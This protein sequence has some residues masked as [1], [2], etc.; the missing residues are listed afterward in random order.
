MP[1]ANK[2][3]NLDKLGEKLDST[4]QKATELTEKLEK[5]VPKAVDKATASLK[6]TATELREFND[7]LIDS[8]KDFLKLAASIGVLDEATKK[9]VKAMDA[10]L[11]LKGRWANGEVG[12]GLSEKELLQKFG[13]S[14]INKVVKA[15]KEH[16]KEQRKIKQEQENLANAQK[17]S[18]KNTK[19][20]TKDYQDLSKALREVLSSIESVKGALNSGSIRVRVDNSGFTKVMDEMK[21]AIDNFNRRKGNERKNF[22]D[23]FLGTREENMAKGDELVSEMK[24]VSSKLETALTTNLAGGLS[25]KLKEQI[26]NGILTGVTAGLNAVATIDKQAYASG[27]LKAV[28]ASQPTKRRVL[29]AILGVTDL[30]EVAVEKTKQEYITKRDNVKNRANA[31]A[32]VDIAAV[33]RRTELEFAEANPN[34]AIA[35]E[36]N[37]KARKAENEATREQIKLEQDL[38]K[39]KNDK[40]FRDR[41]QEEMIRAQKELNEVIGEEGSKLKELGTKLVELKTKQREYQIQSEYGNKINFSEQLNNLDQIAKKTKEWAA[42]SYKVEHHYYQIEKMGKAVVNTLK[43]TSSVFQ[44]TSASLS[45]FGGMFSNVDSFLHTLSG[46]FTNMFRQVFSYARNEVKSLYN[47]GLEQYEKI[48]QAQIGF[49]SFFGKDRVDQITS[50]VRAEAAKTPIVNAGD[51]ADYVMQLAPVSQG[52]ASLALNSSLGILKSLVYSGSDISEGEYVIKNIRDVIAKGTATAIDIR[53]FNRALPGLENAIKQMPELADFI[54]ENGKLSITKANVGKVLDVFAKLNTSEDSPLKDIEEEQLKTLAGMKELF[55]EKRTTAMESILRESGV[56][57]LLYDILGVATNDSM[58]NKVVNFVSNTLRPLVT[59]LSDILNNADW[60]GIANKLK[61]YWGIIKEGIDAAKETIM[62]TGRNIL[63]TTSIDDVFTKISRIVSRFIK[64]IGD[65]VKMA[66]EFLQWLANM[67][68]GGDLE[69]LA[70]TIGMVFFSPLKKIIQTV[71]GFGANT[72]GAASRVLSTMSKFIEAVNKTAL[73]A[74][75]SNAVNYGQMYAAATPQNTQ[76][77]VTTAMLGEL[78]GGAKTAASNGTK[79]TT[80]TIPND[81]GVKI[82]TYSTAQEMGKFK[83]FTS[84]ASAKLK[85]FGNNLK[86]VGAKLLKGVMVGGIVDTLG[87]A[88]GE[89]IKAMRLFGDASED[90]GNAVKSVAEAIAFIAVGASVGGI[91]GGIVGAGVFLVKKLIDMANEIETKRKQLHDEVESI[92]LEGAKAQYAETAMTILRENGVNTD[93]GTDAGKYAYERMKKWLDETDLSYLSPEQIANKAA[94]EF[95][96]ALR[97]KNIAE[98]IVSVSESDEYKNAGGN[99]INLKDSQWADKRNALAEKIEYYRLLGDS[100]NYDSMSAESIVKQF[101][102]GDSITDKQLDMYLSKFG[103]YEQTMSTNTTDITSSL[104]VMGEKTDAVKE[105]L[106]KLNTTI[107]EGRQKLEENEKE[108]GYYNAMFPETALGVSTQHKIEEWDRADDYLYTP[109]YEIDGMK[110]Y[111]TD[112]QEAFS[113]KINE[114]AAKLKELKENGLADSD[115]YKNLQEEL[116]GIFH[117]YHFWADGQYQEVGSV[118]EKMKEEYTWF[119]DKLKE[120]VEEDYETIHRQFLWWGWDEKVRKKNTGGIVFNHGGTVRPIYRATGGEAGVDTVPA[121]LQPGEFVMRKSSVAKVGLST[122]FALNRGDMTAAARSL[123]TRFSGN[124]NNSRNW[125]NTVN[126]NQKSVKNFIQV[127]NRNASSRLN[128]YYGM[129]NRIALAS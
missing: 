107:D 99:V 3:S 98:E 46:K 64:G 9:S 24:S 106:D 122:L 68:S 70:E 17:K 30:T 39:V 118:V 115:E 12:K 128:T 33:T 105:S 44:T 52:N 1:R 121:M 104:T 126:N 41:N 90:I 112:I 40:A 35:S 119:G 28:D 48:Q 10:L 54:D 51:L 82:T 111:H 73:S 125:S 79:V 5:G 16:I 18:N 58:W 27:L 6:S 116:D 91:T 95:A 62:N 63:G 61:T 4:V 96:H 2:S 100:A 75:N 87:S 38:A 42:E 102:G 101:L 77:L 29:D 31:R 84:D 14:A 89:G 109:D 97:F 65:G 72:F 114:M 36:L 74:I 66:M 113:S 19:E 57:D 43:F 123:G 37:A 127:N 23:Q 80:K 76:N 88:I 8:Q 78:N 86:I 22:F 81:N 20:T 45:S 13:Y 71:I 83:T 110:V 129:A 47:E 94:N 85:T 25:D 49:A 67:V 11:D 34:S 53:Q 124:Y 120:K 56:F 15:E 55:E 69:G 59:K 21:K 32:S 103:E 7:S 117:D 60:S 108:N 50:A 92:V 26:S 93:T